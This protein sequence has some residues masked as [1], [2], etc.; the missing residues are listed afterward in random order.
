MQTVLDDSL[1]TGMV[2]VEQHMGSAM[3]KNYITKYELGQKTGIDLPG[4]VMA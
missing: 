3:F 2:Y 1:N 4:E